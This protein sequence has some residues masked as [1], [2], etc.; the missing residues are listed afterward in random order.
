VTIGGA[1]LVRPDGFV[2]WRTER[3]AEDP[4]E[5]VRAAF[6][7]VLAQERALIPA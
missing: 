5:A 4:V 7:A 3:A 6:T 1:V 2:A